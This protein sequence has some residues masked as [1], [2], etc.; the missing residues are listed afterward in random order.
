MILNVMSVMAIYYS[1]EVIKHDY[2][3]GKQYI[4]HPN[5]KIRANNYVIIVSKNVWMW[6]NFSFFPKKFQGC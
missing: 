5:L 6:C 3:I 1:M 4:M 2:Y